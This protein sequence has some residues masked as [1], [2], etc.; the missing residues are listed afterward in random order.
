MNFECEHYKKMAEAYKNKSEMFYMKYYILNKLIYGC[1]NI[2]RIAKAGE[3]VN[4]YI[5]G[6]G[7]I[8]KLLFR[9]LGNYSNINVI[10]FVSKDGDGECE[11]IPVHNVKY[12]QEIDKDSIIV[13]TPMEYYNEICHDIK[14]IN[15]NC[16]LISVIDV[17]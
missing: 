15:G 11:G 6:A 13:I 1:E 2:N 14:N 9:E 5:Y 16:R 7:S 17:L 10:A 4:V 12:I 8:G 3:F